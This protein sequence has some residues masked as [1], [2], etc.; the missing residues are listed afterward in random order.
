[1]GSLHWANVTTVVPSFTGLTTVDVMVPLTYD[2]EVSSAHY[3]QALDGGHIPVDLLFSGT[4]FY[5]D[6]A[7]LLQAVMIPW[8]KEARC[9]LQI[10][11]WREAMDVHF[12]G[13]AWVRLPQ[14][15]F[16]RLQRYRARQA[17]P[18]WEAAV[19]ALLRGQPT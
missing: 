8:D 4:M 6:D 3:L 12:P 2:L 14:A 17:Q 11:T 5:H 13:A 16:E 10:G 1:V 19:E 7:G 9:Q 15:T 18:T